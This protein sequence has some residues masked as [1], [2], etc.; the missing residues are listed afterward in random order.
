M[1]AH[2]SATAEHLLKRSYR[3]G[4]PSLIKFLK[5]SSYLTLLSAICSLRCSLLIIAY[6]HCCRGY[7]LNK[8]LG[9]VSTALYVTEGIF[10]V[11]Y[12]SVMGLA[13]FFTKRQFFTC[14]NINLCFN[15]V[16][17]V[18]VNAKEE[19]Q[20]LSLLWPG[21]QLRRVSVIVKII[22]SFRWLIVKVTKITAHTH[23]TPFN[24]RSKYCWFDSIQHT[25]CFKLQRIFISGGYLSDSDRLIG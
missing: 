3:Y 13:L 2:L 17:L 9:I 19:L 8:K 4:F 1:V 15:H 11:L 25:L 22:I 16:S 6:I 7:R 20:L 24:G 5:Y 10:A 12:V 18:L 21:N 23:T 14:Y